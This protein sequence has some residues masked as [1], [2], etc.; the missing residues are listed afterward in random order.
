MNP[1]LDQLVV[2]SCSAHTMDVDAILPRFAALG[3]RHFEVFTSWAK[4][5]FDYHRD[6]AEYLA[7]ARP[8]GWTFTSFH[9]P[10][11]GDDIDAGIA[12]AV[13]AAK[14]AKALGCE[15][16]LFKATSRPLYIQAAKPFLDAVQGLGVTP[17]L[18]NHFGTP[19]TTLADFREV[20]E[21][22]NDPRMH[23][24]FEVGHFHTA[25]VTWQDGYE[26]LKDRIALVHIKDQVGKTPVKFGEGEVDLRGLFRHMRDV[27]Y[28]GRYVV[29]MEAA[30][31]DA[32]KSI[33]LLGHAR[34]WLGKLFQ[35]L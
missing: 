22:I 13:T 29:E 6:P 7:M 32:E 14:F 9:L 11:V 34:Q 18:Q 30:K 12:E 25:G 24:L 10:P 35:T 5:S 8:Y 2:S 4:S 26:L 21:G 17:V 31:G 28:T 33:E 27:G 3:Y 19:I 20:I 1:S 15:V 16:M 23:H